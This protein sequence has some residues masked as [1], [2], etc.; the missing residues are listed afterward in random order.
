MAALP[1]LHLIAQQV[2]SHS[3]S[4]ERRGDQ[5]PFWG[6]LQGQGCILKRVLYAVLGCSC[7][8]GPSR[9]HLPKDSQV[10]TAARRVQ[11][12]IPTELEP[13]VRMALV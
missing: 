5:Q 12:S 1:F 11:E 4:N 3:H 2:P 9:D 6:L 7:G 13:P 10:C 8:G